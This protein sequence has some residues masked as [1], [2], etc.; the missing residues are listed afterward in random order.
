MMM[1]KASADATPV[2]EG[3]LQIDVPVTA[4]FELE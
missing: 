1:M 4:T 2:S 3:Q